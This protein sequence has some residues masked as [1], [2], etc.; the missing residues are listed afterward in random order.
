MGQL[1]SDP[2]QF[3]REC[4]ANELIS[5]EERRVG[6]CNECFEDRSPDA[7]GDLGPIGCG[8][9]CHARTLGHMLQ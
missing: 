7:D 4:V 5:A 8:F 9:V 6:P 3:Y 2:G 1:G